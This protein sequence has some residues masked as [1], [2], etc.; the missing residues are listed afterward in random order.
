MLKQKIVLFGLAL[1]ALIVT[2]CAVTQQA[3]S[4]DEMGLRQTSLYAEDKTTADST[5]YAKTAPGESKVFARS[6][7]NVPPMIPH[8]VEGMLDITKEM[9]MCMD[10]HMPAMAE[11]VAAT[12]VPA[13]HL[14][15]F[16]PLTQ[17]VGGEFKK[18]GKP[19]ANTSD[20]IVVVH[21]REGL[22]MDRY[23]C[24][25]CHAP[26]SDNALIVPNRFTSVFRSEEGGATSS[27][28]LDVLNDGI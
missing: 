6:F 16:R 15:S 20:I 21:E 8:D 12:P 17:Y 22:S 14:A 19:V 23:T 2:G 25:A 5:N 26:Q 4:E 11:A 24:T 10:C 1:G 13:S 9:N 7:E 18:D 28:L 27:N 3:V